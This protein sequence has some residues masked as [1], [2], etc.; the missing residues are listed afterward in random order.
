MFDEIQRRMNQLFSELE[1]RRWTTFPRVAMASWPLVNLYDVG[2][3][4]VIKA[5]VPGMS[6]KEIQINGHQDVVTITG[7]RRVELPKGYSVHRQERGS[8]QFSRSFTLPCK[9]DINKTS[10]MVRDGLLTIRMVKAEEAKPRQ[11]SVKAE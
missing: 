4:L 3:E 11:I 1:P 6:E 5:Q 10:A 2:E 7:E 8:I 9:I